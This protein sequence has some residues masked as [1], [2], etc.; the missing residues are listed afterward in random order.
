MLNKTVANKVSEY[1][2]IAA[3]LA[4]YGISIYILWFA[5]STLALKIKRLCLILFGTWRVLLSS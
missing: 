1:S 4:Q 2:Q 5:F 3:D